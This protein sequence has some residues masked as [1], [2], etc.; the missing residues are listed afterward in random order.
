MRQRDAVHASAAPDQPVLPVEAVSRERSR[1]DP[2]EE[3][4]PDP[5]AAVDHL[6]DESEAEEEDE[7]GRY[8]LHVLVYQTVGDVAPGVILMIPRHTE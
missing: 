4:Q 7:V 2:T 1:Q 8:V 6:E 5:P 3:D